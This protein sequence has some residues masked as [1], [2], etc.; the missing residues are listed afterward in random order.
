[1]STSEARL[2]IAASETDAD[3]YYATRFLAPDPFIFFQIDAE[4]H[5]LMSDLERD[6]ARTQA[7][8][9]HVL[10]LSEYQK[11]AKKN[12]EEPSQIDALNEVLQEKNITHLNV[13][14]AFA[15]ATADDLRERGYTVAFPEGAYWPDREIKTPEEI[16]HIREAQQ[17]TEAAMDAAIT[18]IRNAEIRGDT[19]YHNG[20]PLTSEAVKREIKFLLLE[21]DY[22]AG[23]TI[24]AGGDQACDPHNEGTGPLPAYQSIIIDIFPRSNTTGYFADLTRTVVKGEPS[25]DLQNI[26]DAVFAGQKL[27]LDSI[28]ADADAQAIH[29]ALT[30]LFENRNFETGNID[31]RMQGFFHG[32][33]HGLGLE[34]HEPPRI[35]KTPQTL[36]AGHITTI[37]PGLYYPGRGAVRIEDLGVV[38]EVGLENLTTYPKFLTV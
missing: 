1:M 8:V 6:R 28:R 26:Y 4:K 21:R 38:T 32:T 7:Q 30:G 37:E 34:I 14:R 31:G 27:V 36:C 16:E 11:K 24:V 10:S 2:M 18:L 20:E 29:E 22:T 9:D 23:H 15:I 17:H 12:N 33:G 13:P 19:L 3:M 25:A 35:G 5:L